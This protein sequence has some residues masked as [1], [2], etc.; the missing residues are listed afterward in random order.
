MTTAIPTDERTQ[1]RAT[2]L[3]AAFALGFATL[4][5]GA[6]PADARNEFKNAFEDEL[7][8]IVAHHVAAVGHAVIAPAVVHH[9]VYYGQPYY[10]AYHYDGPRHFRPHHPR[11]HGHRGH[12]HYKHSRKHH[13]HHRGCGH[14][15]VTVVKKKVYRGDRHDDYARHDWRADRRGHR[16]RYDY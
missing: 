2:L 4:L 16:S 7:G 12:G 1:S 10:R 5:L 15:E 9:E 14:T 11:H 6:S 13:D 8:R 3:G